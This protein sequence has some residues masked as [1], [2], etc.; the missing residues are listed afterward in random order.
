M[1]GGGYTAFYC[2]RIIPANQLRRCLSR[3]TFKDHPCPG[4]PAK[5]VG[6]PYFFNLKV[7]KV[8]L[9]YVMRHYARLCRLLLVVGDVPAE[10]KCQ[11]VVP[12]PK[13]AGGVRPI[14]LQNPSI[15]VLDKIVSKEVDDYL[16]SENLLYENQFGFRRCRSTFQAQLRL[17]AYVLEAYQD[18]FTQVDIVFLDIRKAFDAVSHESL[19]QPL[20]NSGLDARICTYIVNSLKSRY[21]VVN[22]SGFYSDVGVITSGIPQGGVYAPSLFSLAIC[23]IVKQYPGLRPVLFADD[24]TLVFFIN[25]E[26]DVGFYN[27]MLGRFVMH[28]KSANLIVHPDKCSLVSVPLSSAALVQS[29]YSIFSKTV[30]LASE[31]RS[32]GTIIDSNFSF[33]ANSTTRNVKSSSA[34]Y[35]LNKVL[36]Y[37]LGVN[38]ARTIGFN[39]FVRTSNEFDLISSVPK[40]KADRER[41]ESC[42]RVFTKSGFPSHVSY[43]DRLKK[44]G[45][46][47]V[48]KDN[49]VRIVCFLYQSFRR[50]DFTIFQRRC[51]NRRYESR[52]SICLV[53]FVFRTHD[54]RFDHFAQ[55]RGPLLFNA[56]PLELRVSCAEES[57]SL[58]LFK[59]KVFDLYAQ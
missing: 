13:S 36:P 38:K 40:C 48:N 35:A 14:A 57:I 10:L 3:Q 33:K 55:V 49:D 6:G 30:P 46:L 8:V 44:L 25:S 51:P 20:L 59:D 21:F 32:L 50:K 4:H 5:K 45:M 23:D 2:F 34:L 22:N 43:T 47:T 52:G 28:L 27:E 24:M 16:E 56:L 41:L 18:K 54:M 58:K 42:V 39:S 1:G 9:P 31:V 19:I 11:I 17:E 26:V 7:L 15:K 53:F 12:I 37:S 29:Q